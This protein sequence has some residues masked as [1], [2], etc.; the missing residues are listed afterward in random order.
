MY[1]SPLVGGY[2]GARGEWEGDYWA[3]CQTAAV[4]WLLRNRSRYP[5]ASVPPSIG[6]VA[7]DGGNVPTGW[8]PTFAAPGDYYVDNAFWPMPP[9]YE[10]LHT[11]HVEGR[12]L[13]RVGRAP[14]PS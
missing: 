5:T 8:R 9:G 13:C 1:F 4:R 14:A 7:G 12:P 2:P 10:I 3:A 11:V 6:G